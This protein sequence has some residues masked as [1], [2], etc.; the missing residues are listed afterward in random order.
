MTAS[1]VELETQAW[2]D[3]LS[4]QELAL[5]RDY[6]TGNHWLILG[7]LL[8]SALVAWLIV[9]SGVLD[10]VADRLGNRGWALRTFLVA[11]V[12]IVV[13]TLISLP[14]S[15]YRGWWRESAYGR[16]SQPLGDYLA[17]GAISLLLTALIGGL[18]LLGVYWLIR[19][20]GRWWWAWGG[21][22]VAAG[23]SFMLLLSPVLIEPLF[24]QYEPIPEG[25]VRE[26]VLALAQDAGVPEDRV[27]MFDGSRQS[28]N[29]TANVSGVGG[30]ARIAISDVAMDEASLD[31]VVAVTGHEIGH[32]V[33]G[34]VWRSIAVISLLAVA[35]FWLTAR[36]YPWFA[37]KFGTDAPLADPRG[38]PVFVFVLS[39]LLILAQPITN[40]MTR[41]G[42]R[43]ADA[44][45]LATAGLPDALSGALIK[46]A[47]Y[48]YPLA[49]PVEEALLYTHPTVEN[50]IRAAMEWKVRNENS[51]GGGP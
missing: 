13:D 32:Y 41:I 43:E 48:R 31:E 24:N 49:G 6:T 18:F 33:L 23:V 50:R 5:A 40:T 19:K 1:R 36:L 14:W 38:L 22:L 30:Y 37:R 39:L 15:I 12:F 10:K 4:T 35:I 42:E 9:R 29:F 7:G 51:A 11:A 45:S 25:E 3:T 17:Q 20:T 46:T 28:N 34:H 16:T 47:E 21:A 26:A 2:M 44:Y 8:V 27:F